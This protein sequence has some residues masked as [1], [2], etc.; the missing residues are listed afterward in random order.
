MFLDDVFIS[1]SRYYQ[2]STNQEFWRPSVAKDPET[3]G[4][5]DKEDNYEHS[6]GGWL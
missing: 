5:G 2:G 4:N 1:G 6:Y 3:F